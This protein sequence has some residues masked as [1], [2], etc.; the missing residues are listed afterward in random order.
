MT[1][2]TSLNFYFVS[3]LSNQEALPI[4]KEDKTDKRFS[5]EEWHKKF[6]F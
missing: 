3:K 2:I 1:Q 4:T 6:I 5:T